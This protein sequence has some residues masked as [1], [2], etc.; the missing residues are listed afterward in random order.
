MATIVVACPTCGFSLG[1]L[2]CDG[3]EAARN[4]EVGKHLHME[5]R[6]TVS[7]LNG[8]RWTAS[9]DFLLTREA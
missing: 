7:C 8:H 2:N 9:S 3:K 6:G 5:V 4:G 1:V